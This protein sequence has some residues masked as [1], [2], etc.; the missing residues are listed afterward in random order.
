M[1]RKIRI[2]DNLIEISAAT[3]VV[4]LYLSGKISLGYALIGIV[5]ALSLV[6]PFKIKKRSSHL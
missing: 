6:W 4:V 2:A 3:V 1:K 5:I